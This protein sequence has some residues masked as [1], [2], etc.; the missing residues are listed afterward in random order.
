MHDGSRLFEFF[1]DANFSIWM[2]PI[3]RYLI[4]LFSYS[5]AM[6]F[7]IF[8]RKFIDLKKYYP[9]AFRVTNIYLG[10]YLLHFII[11]QQFNVNLGI[12]K[13][14]LVSINFFNR[15]FLILSIIF[16]CA[17]LRLKRGMELGKFHYWNVSIFYD[18]EYF[19]NSDT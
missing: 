9:I 2:T 16:I 12:E 3:K 4:D 6:I 10:W 19:F 1:I 11:F 14:H 13:N 7:V 15:T 17:I 8:A 18:L 5:Q